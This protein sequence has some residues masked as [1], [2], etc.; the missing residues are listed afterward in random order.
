MS[1]ELSR[2]RGWTIAIIAMLTMTVSY[3]D[4]STLAVLA[5]SV[6]K[7]LGLTEAQFGLLASAFAMAYL[8][9]TPL[10][11]WWIDRIGAR[12]GLVPSVLLWSSIAAMHA[13]VPNFAV[14][15][16]LRIALGITEGPGFP[17]AAQT[18]ARVLPVEDRPRGFG[19]LFMGSSIGGMIAPL[20]APRL[21][22][23]GGWRFA[24]LGT[25]VI[26]LAW[27]P[28]WIFMTRPKAV[29]DRL[30]LPRAVTA[31]GPSIGALARDPRMIRAWLGIAAVAP[32]SG[33]MST[34]G[35]KYLAKTFGTK[36][37]DV[38][39][40]LWLPPLLLDLG[41]IGFGDLA[42]RLR[43]GATGDGTTRV[44]HAIAVTIAA[45]TM[46]ALPWIDGAW[47]AVIVGGLGL[48][49]AGGV[50]TLVTSDLIGRLPPGSVS[51]AAGTV[52][53]AQSLSHIIC[54]PLIGRSVDA[55]GDYTVAAVALGLWAI[56]G[57]IA[58]LVWR[59]VGN[60]D[61]ASPDPTPRAS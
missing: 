8:V 20:L 11:G 41:L 3:I 43:R 23:L 18:M 57:S 21:F 35:A 33:F 19:L 59:P 13:L 38:G 51:T 1:T 53:A 24:F 7:A 16:M 22:A 47:P 31:R 32:I 4:R 28:L 26:G 5:P 44:L 27:I 54:N 39:D 14:L 36:Q 25:A 42:V 15:F 10:S 12:R 2:R 6:T 40:Y 55:H 56:P 30:D 9:A 29:R 58:W 17:G 61:A 50:Y 49:G 52:A 34:W 45:S 37:V 48:A 46:I 60:P